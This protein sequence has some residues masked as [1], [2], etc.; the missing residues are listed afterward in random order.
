MR[1]VAQRAH[2]L[3]CRYVENEVHVLL[4]EGGFRI[5]LRRD[6]SKILLVVGGRASCLRTMGP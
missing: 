6:G 4:G 1:R 3:A 2:G 5:G